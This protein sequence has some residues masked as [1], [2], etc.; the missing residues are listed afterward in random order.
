MRSERMLLLL[1]G[2]CWDMS[3]SHVG[4]GIPKK[5]NTST[6]GASGTA[7]RPELPCGQVLSAETKSCCKRTIPFGTFHQSEFLSHRELSPIMARYSP[8]GG[9]A[10][11]SVESPERFRRQFK[12]FFFFPEPPHP[13]LLLERAPSAH[14]SIISALFASL[15]TRVDSVAAKCSQIPGTIAMCPGVYKD[16]VDGQ[17]V[18]D[19]AS[20]APET[21]DHAYARKTEGNLRPR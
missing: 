18:R 15:S 10:P 4:V 6:T 17:G 3:G 19:K 20:R 7:Y 13:Q 2:T 8:F 11:A 1:P 9:K 14:R 12:L 21:I 16:T 5:I